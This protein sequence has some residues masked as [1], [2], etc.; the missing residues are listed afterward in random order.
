MRFQDSEYQIRLDQI[1]S[2]SSSSDL[3]HSS[4]IS[5]ML[6]ALRPLK[7]HQFFAHHE[8]VSQRTS[9]KESIGI[10]DHAAIAHFGK[11]EEALDDVKGM[12]HLY[13]EYPV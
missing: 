10:L 1:R 9:D 13:L 6:D 5:R 2:G 3:A 8:Q 4:T 11:V 12:L 7:A